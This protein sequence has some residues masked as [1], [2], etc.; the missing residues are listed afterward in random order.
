MKKILCIDA[1]SL[2]KTSCGRKFF[3]S[4][5]EGYRNKKDNNQLLYG[6]CFHKCAEAMALGLSEM[7]AYQAAMKKWDDDIGDCEIKYT[8]K[9]LD[10]DHLSGTLMKFFMESKCNDILTKR[11]CLNVNGQTL[12]EC[13]FSIPVYSSDEVDVLVQGTMDGIFQMENGTICIG[14]WKTTTAKDPEGFFYGFKLST[15]LRMYRWAIDW[16]IEH[17]PESPFALAFKGQDKVGAFI[18]GVFLNSKEPAQFRS[19]Q[20]FNFSKDNMKE[21]S[22]ML[23]DAIEEVVHN[24]I[25]FRDTG[26]YP[27]PEGII[28]NSCQEAFGSSC[29]YYHACSSSVGMNAGE[30][31][32]GLFE[33]VLRNNFVKKD[34]RPLTFGGGDKENKQNEKN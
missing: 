34:Y 3:L 32:H 12:A 11:K 26:L 25:R 10:R 13:K 6:T 33:A 23:D 24:W 7:D 19:S 4:V 5:S 20:I 22:E 29:P 21:F 15:Q 1:S 17:Y 8:A 30:D 27:S 9:Y 14:D 18:F 16:Y 31:S 2:K 28:N